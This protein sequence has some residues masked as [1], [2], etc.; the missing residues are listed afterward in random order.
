MAANFDKVFAALA[1]P[2]GGIFHGCSFDVHLQQTEQVVINAMMY[3]IS[4]Y[5]VPILDPDNATNFE[6]IWNAQVPKASIASAGALDLNTGDAD[7]EPEYQPGMVN[8]AG[9]YDMES[10]P[11]RL[12]RRRS[13]ITASSAGRGPAATGALTHYLPQ[14]RFQMNVSGGGRAKVPTA[15][16][17]ALS[18]PNQ[19]VTTTTKISPPTEKEW[20]MLQYL[21]E[22]AI[23]ALKYLIGAT[24]TGAHEPYLAA[25]VFLDKTLAPNPYEQTGNEYSVG[26][27][28][29]TVQG[30]F[31]SSV[32]GTMQVGTLDGDK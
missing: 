16:M 15:I 26:T 27:W 30:S 24:E 29:L 19:D 3:A 20:V 22:T 2:R 17:F 18:N 11:V 13:L 5:A 14:D 12:Y 6:S 9:V 25:A 4:G 23:D 28:N 21:E 32:P 8:W 31:T 7:A 10:G 1:L